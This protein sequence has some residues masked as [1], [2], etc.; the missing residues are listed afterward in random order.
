M[1]RD[2]F[3]LGTAQLV[4][5]ALVLGGAGVVAGLSFGAAAV[6]GL[7]LA[8][9]ATA[10]ALQLLEE[11]GDLGSAYGG[12]AF[13]VLL[14]QD[15]S[16]VGILALMPLLASAGGATDPA[17][18][19]EAAAS[20]GKALAAILAVVL[21]GRYGLN[22]FFRLLAA[23]GAREVMTAAA[24]LVV[25]GTA[26]LMEQVGLSMAMGAFLA[27]ILLAE[28]NFR[29][30]LEAD[31]EPFR[32]MLLG[33]FFMSVG[34]SIDGSLVREVWPALFG[35]TLA[36]ILVKVALVAGLFRL[37]GSDTLGALRGA[38]VLA[39][40][41]EFAFVLLPQAEDLG[42]PGGTATRF[43]VALAALTM[44]IGPMPPRASTS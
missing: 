15:L 6:I 42:L 39:P 29:H 8:L 7:A 17:W 9:S 38:A 1:R 23:S 33:L 12:R 26:L 28:S 3:G 32:G 16:V 21:V 25:L 4:V 35:G 11:R 19:G 43:A 20:T 18:L 34:M 24:L 36:A 37:F 2:I 41:G 44:L 13:A 22:P 27:G 40:A 30:Q 14:F 31:I 10:V 5:C